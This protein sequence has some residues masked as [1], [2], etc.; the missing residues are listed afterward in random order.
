MTRSLVGAVVAAATE[1]EAFTEAQPITAEERFVV[2]VT[3]LPVED[4][5]LQDVAMDIAAMDIAR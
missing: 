1:A 5:R 3:A 2:V 4:M